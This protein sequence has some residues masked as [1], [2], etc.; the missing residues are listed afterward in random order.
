[1]SLAAD[2]R[3]P[4]ADRGERGPL[5]HPGSARDAG[6]AGAAP[7]H[8]YSLPGVGHGPGFEHGSDVNDRL[9]AFLDATQNDAAH[10]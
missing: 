8:R 6:Q 4:D 9:L 5:P 7:P 2:G 10:R 3:T 1:M